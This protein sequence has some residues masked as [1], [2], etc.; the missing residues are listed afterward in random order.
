[1]KAM[2]IMQKNTV[3]AANS[4]GTGKTSSIQKSPAKTETFSRML[5]QYGKTP[6]D[7]VSQSQTPDRSLTDAKQLTYPVKQLSLI[8]I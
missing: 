3:N 1:M 5:R 4:N 7:T 2:D 8:H 6:A